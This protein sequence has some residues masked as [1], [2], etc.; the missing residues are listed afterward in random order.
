[1]NI[2]KLEKSDQIV[3]KTIAGSQAYNLHT[4]ASDQDF[5]GLFYWPKENYLKFETPSEQINDDKQNQIYYSLKRFFTLASTANPNILELLWMPERV[6][7]KTTVFFQELQ[8]ERKQFLSKK[9]YFTYSGYSY[10]QIKKARSQNKLIMNPREDPKPTIEKH[11][12]FID[13]YI[14]FNHL[15]K[16]RPIPFAEKGIKQEDYV[17]A[18]VEGAAHLYRMYKR[19]GGPG[20]FRSGQLTC[21]PI[22][23]EEEKDCVGLMLFNEDA[24]KADLKEWNRYHDWKKNRNEN[25]WIAQEKG[26]IDYDAKNI[27][28]CMRLLLCSEKALTTGEIVVEWN[29]PE[30]DLLMNIRAGKMDFDELM[31]IV[32]DKNKYLEKLYNESDVIPHSINQ[33]KIGELYYDL[34]QAYT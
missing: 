4:P 10:A 21:E 14:N 34:V 18:R 26:E 20:I 11:T 13:D 1:M 12:F 23:I 32:E 19:P 27:M 28:H 33:K 8:K 5:R 7:E 6:V 3:F 24:Y 2:E 15:C 16:F 17:V 22:P 29:G 25:R 31:E 9:I 30:R